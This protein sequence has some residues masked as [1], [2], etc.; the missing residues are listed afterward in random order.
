M[1]FLLMD[2]QFM[3]FQLIDYIVYRLQLLMDFQFMDLQFMEYLLM[4]VIVDRVHVDGFDWVTSVECLAAEHSRALVYPVSTPPLLFQRRWRS[5]S[6]SPSTCRWHTQ[7]SRLARRTPWAQ[8]R[9]FLPPSHRQVWNQ[10]KH[11]QAVPLQYNIPP[12]Y[13]AGASGGSV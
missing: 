1:D 4:K 2:F 8:E 6:P 7:G 13:F 12:I 10:A 5:P 11:F 9:T 3:D